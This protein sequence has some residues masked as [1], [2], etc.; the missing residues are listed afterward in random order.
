MNAAQTR[1]CRKHRQITRKRAQIFATWDKEMQNNR[2]TFES[3]KAIA[4]EA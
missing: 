1:K 4:N 3:N 2:R